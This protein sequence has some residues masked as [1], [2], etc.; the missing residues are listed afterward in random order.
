MAKQLTN[1]NFKQE[2]LESDGPVLVDFWATWCGPCQRQGPVIDE[3]AQA[4]FAV[5]KVDI[6]QSAD[7][8]AQYR[9]MSVPTLIVFKDGRE[10]KRLVGLHSRAQLEQ[11]IAEA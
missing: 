7:L 9:V 2:V 1:A 8:A 10:A 4:G 6:D 5:G 11:A 3:L